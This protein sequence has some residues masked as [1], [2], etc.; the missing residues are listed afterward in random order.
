MSSLLK[1]LFK[2]FIAALPRRNLILFESIPDFSDN[3][4]AVFDEMLRRN[5][6][7]RYRLVWLARSD[8]ASLPKAKNVKAVRRDG[9]LGRL[10]WSWM[11]LRARCLIC[12]NEFLETRNAGQTSFYLTHGTTV[13]SIRKY[14]V[15]PDSIDHVLVASEHLREM[16]AYE[17]NTVP[18][19]LTA[20][21]FP[22]NDAMKR[23]GKNVKAL[24]E[25]D[26]QKIAVWYPTYRQHKNGM[27]T[28]TENALPLLGDPE[29]ARRVNEEAKRLGVLLVLKPHFAQDVSKIKA[30]KLS[31]IRFID[32]SFF[33]QN[34]ISSYEFV[35][36]CDALIT[37]YSSIYFDFLLCHKPVAV[38]WDD[39][40]DYKKNPG[41]AIDV[42]E[43][44]AG[45][46]K[47]YCAEELCAFLEDLAAGRDPLAEERN[48]INALANVADDDE[49]SRRVVDFIA[50]KA[51]LKA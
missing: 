25:G 44:M 32:D 15:V 35:G 16:S 33:T 14:Y 7:E 38:V 3:T 48:R 8:K 27:T 40:E 31:H 21:G 49:S 19:K 23:G 41:L 12:C 9:F 17:F 10:R 1:R 30:Q 20:L 50:K 5:M 42:E 36:S 26:F 24:F 11:T 29:A 18:E 51:G 13:K 45:A 6:N 37:D 46:H 2:G 43:Y 39:I 47:I 34:G 28:G 4:R 22:R